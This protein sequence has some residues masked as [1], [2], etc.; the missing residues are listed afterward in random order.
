[1]C[2]IVCAY[3]CICVCKCVRVCAKVCL[4]TCVRVCAYAYLP[5]LLFLTIDIL[6]LSPPSHTYTCTHTGTFL[7]IDETHTQVC[8]PGGLKGEWDLSCDGIILGTI[9]ERVTMILF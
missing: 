2:V 8:G 1:M 5:T 7:L 6:S 3:A 4:R 9:P